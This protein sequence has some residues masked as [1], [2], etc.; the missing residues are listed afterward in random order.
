MQEPANFVKHSNCKFNV[1]VRTWFAAS[2]LFIVSYCR[3]L[4]LLPAAAV[5]RLLEDLKPFLQWNKTSEIQVISPV[6]IRHS[7]WREAVENGLA[8]FWR[9]FFF[10][11]SVCDRLCR[12]L[13]F[14][15]GFRWCKKTQS[16]GAAFIP[17]PQAQSWY[18]RTLGHVA[19]QHPYIPKL[20]NIFSLKVH[21]QDDEPCLIFVNRRIII[22][23]ESSSKH[24]SLLTDVL[25]RHV[26]DGVLRIDTCA[27]A[28]LHIARRG[29]A[30]GKSV[31]NFFWQRNP[32]VRRLLHPI[33]NG[34][35]FSYCGD[36]GSCNGKCLLRLWRSDALPI[37]SRFSI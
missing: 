33:Q 3:G 8:R 12:N 11:K 31:L 16:K 21:T 18:L 4:W 6:W 7:R 26:P 17:V 19:E 10:K 28:V 37:C 14:A 36:E 32:I 34:N 2:C 25:P 24:A 5:S 30:I 20:L 27:A 9:K 29:T 13:E 1:V 22:S 23:N 35:M 15:Q